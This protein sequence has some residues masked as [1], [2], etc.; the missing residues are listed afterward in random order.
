MLAPSSIAAAKKAASSPSVIHACYNNKT[1]AL[2]V[3]SGRSC[4]RGGVAISWIV[5]GV[6][7]PR[8]D[9]GES[10]A[11]LGPRGVAGEVGPPG[12]PGEPGA[13]GAAAA[14]GVTGETGPTGATGPSGATGAPGAA[15]EKGPRGENGQP[16]ATGAT[17]LAGATGPTGTAGPPGP[18]GPEGVFPGTLPKEV[19]ET[20]AWIAASGTPP[21]AGREVAGVISFP[22]P[23]AKRPVIHYLNHTETVTGTAECPATEDLEK[24]K[25][26]S[27][28]LCIYTGEE[29]LTKVAFKNVQNVAG[30][31]TEKASL[32]GAFVIFSAS[33]T[34]TN[35]V[36]V[37]QGTWA[38]TG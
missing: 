28:S 3:L 8:G 22:V 19:T 2:R 29:N 27:G 9:T 25:A 36:A 11:L 30:E 34:T 37:V 26:A 31:P 20:G 24:P 12:P 33:E 14:R 10:G 23:L 15:G 16:G 17:G 7:G 35:N 1:G 18:T 6:A 13:P 21:E 5:A 38:V 4:G 32:T